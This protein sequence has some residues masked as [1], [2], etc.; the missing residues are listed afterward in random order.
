MYSLVGL[1]TVILLY[2]QSLELFI[3]KNWNCIPLK[4]H[5][6]SFSHSIVHSNHHFT[7][8]LYKFDYSR[9]PI[10]VEAYN[11]FIFDTDIFQL[12]S[13]LL[14]SIMSYMLSTFPF[15]LR[16]NNIPLYS[17]TKFV[18][19]LSANEMGCSPFYSCA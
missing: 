8:C 14:G 7:S 10:L 12:V 1:I 16:P 9:Y 13:C 6:C 18:I 3:L 17:W 5:F 4:Q 2:N 15:F 19:C 11:I